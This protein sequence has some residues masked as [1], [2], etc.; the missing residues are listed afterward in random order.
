MNEE[1]EEMM[2]GD[3]MN[4]SERPSREIREENSFEEVMNFCHRFVPQNCTGCPFKIEHV[5]YKSDCDWRQV[6]GRRPDE[7]YLVPIDRMLGLIKNFDK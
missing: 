6:V 3:F 4:D 1:D 2:V 5:L 7:W